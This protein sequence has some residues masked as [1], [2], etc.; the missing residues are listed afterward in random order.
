MLCELEVWDWGGKL[1]AT[2]RACG[3]DWECWDGAELCDAPRGTAPPPN[4]FPRSCAV[5][6][7]RRY[8][9]RGGGV[10][11]V[12]G[13]PRHAT[14]VGGHGGLSPATAASW[15]GGEAAEPRTPR[16]RTLPPN[17]LTP[18]PSRRSNPSPKL[19][20]APP[21]FADPRVGIAAAPEGDSRCCQ[22]KPAQP[23]IKFSFP[24]FF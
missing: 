20:A 12:S 15:Q 19:R 9:R 1:G 22:E 2:G 18:K 21:G 7:N 17:F 8:R 23:W 10:R 4:R 13:H 6:Q 14:G 16:G 3:R 11:G 24:A 5:G